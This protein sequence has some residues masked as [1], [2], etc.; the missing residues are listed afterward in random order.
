MLHHTKGVVIN[1]IK[2]RETSIIV[3]IYTAAFGI[4]SYIVNGARSTKSRG[5]IAL[6]QPLTLLDLVVYH[7]PNKDLHRISEAKCAIPFTSIPF[8]PIKTGISIF[9]TEIFG[10]AL[11]HESTNER[12]F[13]FLFNAISIFDRLDKNVEN[14]HLQI[15]LK[16]S[17]YL[18]FKPESENDF[19]QQLIE[20]GLPST[21]SSTD[22][23]LLLDLLKYNLGQD[24]IITNK[25]R[26]DILNHVV[27][28]YGVHVESLGEIKSLE[29]LK[30]VLY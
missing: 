16:S 12:F 29:I 2:Y 1:Y 3:R 10:K 24:V 28:Y 11:R 20:K 7:K 23:Q 25:S 19:N 30:E 9:L 14:F 13:E 18:G 6:Y 26:R 22:Y 27:R 17:T 8:E 4:Q 5:K 15:L 21:L